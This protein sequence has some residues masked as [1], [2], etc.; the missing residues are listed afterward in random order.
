MFILSLLFDGAKRLNL[1][2]AGALRPVPC[3]ARKQTLHGALCSSS[4]PRGKSALMHSDWTNCA[5]FVS[6]EQRA[7]SSELQNDC[8]RL[9]L[10]TGSIDFA[11]VEPEP[12]PAHSD[13][14]LSTGR[15]RFELQPKSPNMGIEGSGI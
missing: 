5:E 7:A 6:S 13:Q 2:A 1:E 8:Y 15:V 10:H 14:K 12:D 3:R 9:T 4:N 11:D